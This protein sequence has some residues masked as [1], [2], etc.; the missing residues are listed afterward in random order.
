MPLWE[1]EEMAVVHGLGYPNPNR[2]HFKSIALWESGGDGNAQRHGGW[3]THDIEH[4]Y[5]IANMDAHGISLGGGMGIFES[6]AGNWISMASADQFSDVQ[7]KPIS[8]PADYSNKTLNTLLER[9]AVLNASIERIAGKVENNK[10]PVAV[11]GNSS[12]NK[13]LTHAIN[14]INS[15]VNAPVLKISLGNFD[16]HESQIAKQKNLL[17]QLAKGISRLRSELIKTDN[18]NNTVVL[19]YSEFG[20]RAAQNHNNGTDHGTATCHFVFGG[21]VNGGFHGNHPDLSDLKNGDLQ[22]TMDYRA[23]YSSML[24]DWLQLPT[25]SFI[26]YQ[27]DLLNPLFS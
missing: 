10:Y 7:I 8:T 26:R 17:R 13:Q 3:M 16:T 2:S 24:S 15:G 22:F 23:L 11:K 12:I 19:T 5:A 4:A 6:S 1:R 9:S 18:W 21:E 20:R 14:L 27:S 25:N